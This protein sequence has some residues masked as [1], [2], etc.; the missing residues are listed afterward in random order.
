[1]K[2]ISIVVPAYNEASNLGELH[3]RVV[4]ALAADHAINDPEKFLA[5][6]A[7]AGRAAGAGRIVT[8]GITPTSPA[9][10]YGYLRVGGGVLGAGAAR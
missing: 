8:L 1:M 10:G 7:E 6:C 5:L 3:R 4:A 9:T 2:K